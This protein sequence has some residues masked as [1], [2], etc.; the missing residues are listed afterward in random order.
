MVRQSEW[1]LQALP[2]PNLGFRNFLDIHSFLGGKFQTLRNAFCSVD[3]Y[4]VRKATPLGAT[5]AGF[6][7]KSN[8]SLY[9]NISQSCKAI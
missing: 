7:I 9:V 3:S 4:T 5:L 1:K 2:G 6:V 8:Y